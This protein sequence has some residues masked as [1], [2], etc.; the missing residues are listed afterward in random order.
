M[1]APAPPN[2]RSGDSLSV[3]IPKEPPVSTTR[4]PLIPGPGH[5]IEITPFGAALAFVVALLTCIVAALVAV[6]RAVRVDPALAFD[7]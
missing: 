1:G 2:R 3:D 5:P 7:A 6:Q 4:E